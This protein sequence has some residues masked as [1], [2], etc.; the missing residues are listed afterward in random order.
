MTIEDLLEEIVGEIRDENDEE[1]PPIH[2]RGGGIID[3]DGRV[4]LSDLERDAAI[5]L[6]PEQPRIE[7]LGGYIRARLA[8]PA[9]PA[10]R[11]ACVGD[12]LVVTDVAGRR[13]RRVRIVPNAAPEP[14][15][16]H[17][18]V[19]GEP[20]DCQKTAENEGW[21]DLPPQGSSALGVDAARLGE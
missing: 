20:P 16:R 1:V 14:K 11:I 3:V 18:G 6:R 17:A 2:R 13:V 9:E 4:L 7:T 12:T 8:R 15:D 19:V 10:A 21:R 5:V